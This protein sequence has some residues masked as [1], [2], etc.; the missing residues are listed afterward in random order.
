MRE[1]A[2]EKDKGMEK[3]SWKEVL[4]DK[5]KIIYTKNINKHDVKINLLIT[6]K[7][8]DNTVSVTVSL[9]N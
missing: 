5:D 9:A 1:P 6:E 4:K 2:A 8:E 3:L 7:K